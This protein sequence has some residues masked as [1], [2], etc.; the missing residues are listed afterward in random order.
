MENYVETLTHYFEFLSHPL[1][2]NR[3]AKKTQPQCAPKREKNLVKIYANFPLRNTCFQRTANS[4]KVNKEEN[5]FA[6]KIVNNLTSLHPP[7]TRATF[8]F[9]CLTDL[10]SNHINNFHSECRSKLFTPWTKSNGTQLIYVP[11]L[12][13]SILIQLHKSVGEKLAHQIFRLASE[14]L[15]DTVVNMAKRFHS[16]EQK[17]MS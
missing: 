10:S 1:P 13:T 4:D 2:F 12:L 14:N 7:P 17:T 11:I 8:F 9:L 16:K 15:V 6:L 3:F 5:L